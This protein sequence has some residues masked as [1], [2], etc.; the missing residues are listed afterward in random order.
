[1]AQKEVEKVLN[2][3]PENALALSVRAALRIRFKEFEK[4]TDD[5]LKS[6]NKDPTHPFTRFMLGKVYTLQG[7][8]D[9]A[10]HQIY[11]CLDKDP[12]YPSAL[13]VLGNL[14]IAETWNPEN[15]QRSLISY[16]KAL[17]I[18]PNHSPSLCARGLIY[19]KWDATLKQ[20]KILKKHHSMENLKSWLKE[21]F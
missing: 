14:I 4:A 10:T 19:R 9:Q 5:L 21:I 2:V 15:M 20:R 8:Y 13:C 1:M 3:D 11:L 16:E 17:S 6:V 7:K 12:N 18:D